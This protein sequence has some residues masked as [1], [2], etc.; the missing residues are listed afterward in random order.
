MNNLASD[1]D[2]ILE[3]TR[4]LWEEV[5]G[6]RIFLTGG[7]GFFGCW[8]LESFLW[9]NDHLDLNASATVLTRDPAAFQRKAPHLAA[10]PSIELHGGDVR[11]FTFPDGPF[12]FV[13]HAATDARLP[14]AAISLDYLDTIAQGTR[15]ALEFARHSGASKFLLTSSGAV[16]GKQPSE[17]SHV[18]EDYLGAPRLEGVGSVYGEG[19]RMAEL[20][21]SLYA[22]N[23]GLECKIARC[24]AFVGPHLP[25]DAHFAI[26]NF[27]RD[28]LWSDRIQVKSDGRSYRSYL[29]AADLAVWLWTIL[30]RGVSCR[31]YNVGSET[32]ITIRDLAKA[33]ARLLSPDLPVQIERELENAK[34]ADRYVPST[35]RA[36]VELG[37]CERV[38][39]DDAILSTARWYRGQEGDNSTGTSGVSVAAG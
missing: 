33:V 22:S 16:Y 1:L 30:L 8:L 6:K 5:R 4:G 37:L 24:F 13:I 25:L 2:H 34:P 7:T 32:A 27:I 10:H 18:A 35:D 12:H 11:S 29:Y 26:G 17:V 14:T 36:R 23:Y 28:A 21:C 31:P 19:K 20:L 38:T 9:A 39:L 3:H 15:Y